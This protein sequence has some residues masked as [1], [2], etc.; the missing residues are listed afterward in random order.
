MN[1]GCKYMALG[2]YCLISFPLFS[3]TMYLE[4]NL[5]ESGAG[6]SRSFV[7]L[8]KPKLP[9]EIFRVIDKAAKD[10]KVKGIILNIGS[11]SGD[12]GYLW[13]LRRELE[14]FK[15]S[16]G[17]HGGKKIC[18]YISN[19]DMDV[20]CLATVADKI[21]MDELGTLS[22]L[23][24]SMNRAYVK[25]TLE[26]LGVGVRELRYLEYKSASETFTRDSMSEA[27]RRQYSEYLDDIF[28]LTGDTIK[29]ARNMTDEN[30]N[31]AVNGDFLYSSKGAVNRGLVDHSG[32]KDAVMRAIKEIEGGEVKNFAL[33]GESVSSL[34]GDV[35][36]YA[37]PK[38]GGRPFKRAPVIAVINANG[39]TDMERGM[40]ALSLAEII[41]EAAENRRVKA[42]V[43]RMESPGGSAE[44]ADHLA[45]AVRFAKEKVPV[46]VSM[47]EVAASGGY[48]ASMYA[49]RILASPFTI[50]GSIGVI[51]SWFYDNGFNAKLGLSTD[52]IQRGSHADLLTGVILPSRDLT[53]GEEERYKAYILEIYNLFTAKVA[54]GRGMDIEKAEASA[55]GRIFSG[56]RALEA[57]LIDEVGGLADALRAARALAEIPED[58][59]V[60]YEEYPKPKFMD[61]IFER[62]LLTKT[63]AITAAGGIE[64]FFPGAEIR[65]EIMREIRCR[66]QNN[67]KVMPILPL[68]FYVR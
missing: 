49:S 31:A 57:G 19:A 9:V 63:S 26:K 54:L 56:R 14:K 44:A 2:M 25:N 23:G 41:R 58:R 38:S 21:V 8:A 67:G 24:Y 52:V 3:Q 55:Q 37:P 59:P 30:F 17:L 47:G 12:R 46:V 32:R 61:K 60:K 62:F 36:A 16:G 68:D 28:S 40:A 42:I 27:D 51:G 15:A 35:T 4:L 18:A 53:A 5:N 34:C 22:L 20:Y 48:W 33:Y 43:I 65:P 64:L 39:Q 66:L 1:A 45:E 13:E 50:T 11:I 6:A 10:N 29:K 7:S